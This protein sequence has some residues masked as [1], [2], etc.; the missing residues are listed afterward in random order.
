[1]RGRTAYVYTPEKTKTYQ[2]VVGWEAKKVCKKP[3]KGPVAV[4]MRLFSM[5]RYD[6]DNVAK[7]ILDGMNGI[8][9]EDDEQVSLLIVSKA[10]VDREQYE[11]AEIEIMPLK[12]VSGLPARIF[13]ERKA[14][15]VS[16]SNQTEEQGNGGI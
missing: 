5:G 3:L 8:C 1:M 14:K 16:G 13:K 7:S 4:F 11:R 15:R 10:K 6:L 12:S 9:Y 2:Q